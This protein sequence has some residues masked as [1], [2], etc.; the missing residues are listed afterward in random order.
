MDWFLLYS[1]QWELDCVP[2]FFRPFKQGVYSATNFLVRFFQSVEPLF[3]AVEPL[4]DLV[5]PCTER[6]QQFFIGHAHH[7]MLS[8]YGAGIRLSRCRCSLGMVIVY[9][10]FDVYSIDNIN[11]YTS[12]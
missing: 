8:L 6:L 11:K 3:Y 9:S 10:V 1:G 5:E 7:P 2:A 12:L 4:F